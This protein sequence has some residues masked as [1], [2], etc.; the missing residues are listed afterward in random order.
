MRIVADENIPLVREFFGTLGEVRTVAPRALSREHT[1]QADLLVVRSV[2][3]IPA[4]LVKGTPVRFVGTC[5]AGVD[6]LDGAGLSA[7]GIAWT[8][9]PGC[10]ANSVVNYVFS[11]LA[12]LEGPWLDSTVGPSSMGIV[13]CGNVGGLLYRRVRELGLRC[14]VYDPFLT[15]EQ[16]PDLGPLEE[17]LGCDMVCIHAPHT[18]GGPHP[19]H[20]LLG[21]SELHQLKPGALLIN[22]G[23]GPVV[24]N[25]ALQALLARRDDLRVVLDVWE[26]EPDLNAELVERVDL[27]TPHIAGHSYDGKVRGTEMIYRSVCD[28]L[29]LP[30]PLTAAK[31]DP[32]PELQ[33]LALSAT[34]PAAALNQAIL[35]AYDVREDDLRFRAAIAG[36]NRPRDA[37]DEQRKHYPIRREFEHFTVQPLEPNPALEKQLQILGFKPTSD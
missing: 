14:R 20:H 19:S 29:G 25:D 30:A 10:N 33:S 2:V 12:A 34:A 31:F 4:A 22:A 15:P 6:H 26:N 28:F 7:L 35:G 32:Q 37:F 3:P 18:T 17:V 27:A 1:A 23:R 5:T 36:A 9:A 21:A 8:G 24:D 11:T 13:G 16:V